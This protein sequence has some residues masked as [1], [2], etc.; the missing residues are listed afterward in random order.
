MAVLKK[1][2]LFSL[3]IDLSLWLGATVYFSFLAANE[4]FG[5]L[6]IDAASTAIGLLF[7]PYFTYVTVLSIVGWFLYWSLGRVYDLNSRSFR[8]GHIALFVGV[9]V[10][11]VNR[12]ILLPMVHRLTVEMGPVSKANPQLFHQFGMLHGISM[13][14]DLISMIAVFVT[15]ITLTMNLKADFK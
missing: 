4:L 11:I 12:F 2:V 8:V 13:L 14:L 1:L 10:A 6:P 3:A 5:G 9:V 7:P 15:W